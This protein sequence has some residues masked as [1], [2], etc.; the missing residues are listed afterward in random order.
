MQSDRHS[1]KRQLQRI[2]IDRRRLDEGV[3]DLATDTTATTTINKSKQIE[4]PL[5]QSNEH[6]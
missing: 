1:P 4:L 2:V 6:D 5:I 3:C